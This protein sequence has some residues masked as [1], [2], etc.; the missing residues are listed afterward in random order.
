MGNENSARVGL[1]TARSAAR[2]TCRPSQLWVALGALSWLG[3]S[4]LTQ[5]AN[6]YVDNAATGANN[7][8]SWANA[9]SSLSSVVWG[10]S[11]VRAGDTLFLSG[12]SAA[13]VYTETWSVGASGT[14]GS[15]IRIAIDAANPNHNGLAIF[16][17]DEQGDTC[18]SPYAIYCHQDDVT[19]DGNVG[20]RPHL[21]IRNLRN[22]FDRSVGCALWGSGDG[23]TVR[24]VAITNC[25]N[26]INLSGTGETVNHCQ[27]AGIRGDGGIT[28]AT[29]GGWDANMIY[30]N[31]IGCLVNF[32]VPPGGSGFYDG[33]D[34]IQAVS[35]ISIFGNRI[36]ETE[37]SAVYTSTQ[38][39]DI[40]QCTG[41]YVKFYDNEIINIGD[42]GFDY[43]CY[44]NPTPHDVWIYNNV[45]HITQTVDP[46]PEYFRLYTSMSDRPIA[47]FYN[48]KILNNTFVDCDGGNRTIWF[49]EFRGNPNPAA[50]GIEIKNNIFYNCGA[51]GMIIYVTNSTGITNGS[52]AFDGNVYYGNGT[53]YVGYRGTTYTTPNWIAA[54]EP[55]GKVAQPLFATYTYQGAS[56][57]FHLQASDTVARDAGL[58]LSAYFGTDFDGVGRPQG[59][60]W[61]I[62][63]YEYRS[64]RPILNISWAT[65]ST[66]LLRWGSETGR[67]YQV[68]FSSNLKTWGDVGS[69]QA[70]TGQTLSHTVTMGTGMQAY[71]LRVN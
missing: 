65:N 45:Y 48:F 60:T 19:F 3:L 11:G 41:N 66:L 1:P 38:H 49:S 37:T 63:A 7:G 9:W 13:K 10:S 6:W 35:G 12:G 26:G 16:D 23:L 18:S 44:A 51:S 27:L 33:P 31:F 4:P 68:E 59:T 24:Y 8:T 2:K 54:H 57:D 43:D 58:D 50:W 20:G 56:N 71:R 40:V 46:Y 64:G 62:G 69:A 55:H 14:P 61:D 39:P 53:R 25:N 17:Y 52:F 29:T 21:V 36:T 22:H 42:S 15:P 32:S 70:G 47:C 28:F 5:A 34:P 30:S 67:S